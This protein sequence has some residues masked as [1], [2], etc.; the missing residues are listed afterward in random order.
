M[1]DEVILDTALHARLQQLLLPMEARPI[2]CD[3]PVSELCYRLCLSG[4]A[5]ESP[6]LGSTLF[7]WCRRRRRLQ[8]SKHGCK[9]RIALK[10][11]FENVLHKGNAIRIFVD[12]KETHKAF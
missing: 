8:A 1:I 6:A 7:Y 10:I 9:L 2:D 11:G 12:L 4:D 3:D 5:I